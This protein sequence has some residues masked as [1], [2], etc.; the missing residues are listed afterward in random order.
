MYVHVKLY[1]IDTKVYFKYCAQ[2]KVE[3]KVF[4]NMKEIKE[5]VKC[6]KCNDPDAFT[7]L[8][9]SQM[10]NMYKTANAILKNDEDAADAIQETIIA[11][12]Q[13]LND[14]KNDIYFRTWMTRILINKCYEIIKKNEKVTYM[15]EIPEV[16]TESDFSNVEWKE[17]MSVLD[18]KY[19]LVIVLYYAQGFSTKEIAGMLKITAS[20]VRTRLSR[21]REQLAKYYGE[22]NDMKGRL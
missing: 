22:N 16:V 21:G 2:R 11:C 1:G 9:Q 17:A 19:R 20:T 12:W 13:K 14:L 18:E 10:Q 6:A 8:M 7:E 3:R 15:E 5:L 4:I